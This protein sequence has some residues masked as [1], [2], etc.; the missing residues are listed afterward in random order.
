MTYSSYREITHPSWYG[1]VTIGH[2]DGVRCRRVA[3]L[4]RADN[5]ARC[6]GAGCRSSVSEGGN[7]IPNGRVSLVAGMLRAIAY[8]GASPV[9]GTEDFAVLI[10]DHPPGGCRCVQ[11]VGQGAQDRELSSAVG[12]LSQDLLGGARRPRD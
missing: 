11:R 8:Q 10:D 2:D 9:S 5:H 4:V 1:A 12:V 7:R 6:D 3:P